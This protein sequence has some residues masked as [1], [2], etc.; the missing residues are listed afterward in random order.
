MT[1]SHANQQCIMS[2][3]DAVTHVSRATQQ[4]R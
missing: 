3:S 1:I 2:C 4:T